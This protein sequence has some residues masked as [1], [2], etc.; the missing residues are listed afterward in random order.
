MARARFNFN[1][2]G[3]INGT[4]VTITD[5]WSNPK[6]GV[7]KPSPTFS[8]IPVGNWHNSLLASVIMGGCC[9]IDPSTCSVAT[10][11]P[12]SSDKNL[13]ELGLTGA[14]VKISSTSRAAGT[15]V[16]NLHISVS[17]GAVP[18]VTIVSTTPFNCQFVTASSTAND[19]THLG[20]Q[21]ALFMGLNFST[22]TN[23]DGSTN[24]KIT[25][26][27]GSKLRCSIDS[28]P[29]T[30]F[31][32]DIE[33]DMVVEFSNVTYSAANVHPVSPDTSIRFATQFGTL[34]S[35]GAL[36]AA[37]DQFI[38]ELHS[39]IIPKGLNPF[40]S[41]IPTSLNSITF[42][43]APHRKT[44]WDVVCAV[45]QSIGVYTK[46]KGKMNAEVDAI[47]RQNKM[48]QLPPQG[49]DKNG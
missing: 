48:Q 43:Q 30:S 24:N 32:G 1:I 5:S 38:F 16:T 35:T 10:E 46:L 15:M 7:Y 44:C 12:T 18:T 45:W 21:S 41:L 39:Y 17:G 2:S 27:L 42:S 28:A 8:A 29:A 3:T 9:V 49:K 22:I 40:P 34:K 25:S 33:F 37:N 26:V 20:G 14:D 36:G 4:A 6:R 23:P 19:V 13:L 31:P 47:T 11:T